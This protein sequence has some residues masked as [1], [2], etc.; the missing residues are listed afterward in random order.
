MN[1]EST[2]RAA[3]EAHHSG[4][5]WAQVARL[6]QYANGSVARRAALR[7]AARIAGSAER[8]DNP[9]PD[10]SAPAHE[11]ANTPPDVE[12]ALDAT[13]Y[14]RGFPKAK[15]KF[16]KWNADGSLQV[17]GGEGGFA[18]YR[19]YHANWLSNVPSDGI[20]AIYVWAG[21]PSRLHTRVSVADIATATSAPEATVRKALRDRPDVFR[22]LKR[23]L[24]EIRDPKADRATDKAKAS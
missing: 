14:H 20:A 11:V 23:D 13:I 18:A 2:D 15:F 10:A 21:Q 7:H 5:T 24:Y 1:T 3:W 9:T 6:L 8:P 17:Y 19:D 16:V 4:Q 22:R 12:L